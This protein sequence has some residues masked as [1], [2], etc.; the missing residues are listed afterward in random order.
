[1]PDLNSMAAS[2]GALLKETQQSIAVTESSC[3]GLI[4]A[5]LVAVPGASAYYVGGAVVYTRTSQRGLLQ[6]PD[7]AMTDIRASSEPYALLNARTVRES[8]GTTWAL[9]ETGASGPT[10]NRYGD[11]AGHACIAVAGPVE[12]AITV[13]TGDSDRE[14][15]M[16]VFARAAL[17]LLEQCVQESR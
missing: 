11:S 3:G 2:V 4:S 12:R 9:S 8:L 14:A 10:G 15:N 7:E 5:S 13:E 16:W 1:M 6:V 17:D